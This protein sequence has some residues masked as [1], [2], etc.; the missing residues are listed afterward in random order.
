MRLEWATTA[1]E[2]HARGADLGCRVVDWDALRVGDQICSPA[3][4]GDE[5]ALVRFTNVAQALR[6]DGAVVACARP[7]RR[8]VGRLE[9]ALAAP[10]DGAPSGHTRQSWLLCSQLRLL[11]RLSDRSIRHETVVY[12]PH[13]EKI[14]MDVLPDAGE[15]FDA[16]EYRVA[17][18]TGCAL[19]VLP[20]RSF[21][22][23]V[24]AG[25][26]LTLDPGHRPDGKR[27]AP[28]LMRAVALALGRGETTVRFDDDDAIELSSATSRRLRVEPLGWCCEGPR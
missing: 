24:R 3:D 11:Y 2:G 4:L 23:A 26:H 22:G 6:K 12:N 27:R 20:D 8:L 21:A 15:P 25:Q 19:I 18:D 1:E 16:V 13:S 7:D 17:G 9:R 28:A 14:D 5:T 10:L